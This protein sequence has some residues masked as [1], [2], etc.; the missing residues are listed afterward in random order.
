MDNI[1]SKKDKKS[2]KLSNALRENLL[3]RKRQ[4]KEKKEK[5]NK[6]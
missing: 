6:Q 3:K 4:A 1:E 5:R 2:D